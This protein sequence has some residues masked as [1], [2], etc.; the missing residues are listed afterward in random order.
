[1]PAVIKIGLDAEE[2]FRRT[3][4]SDA[5]SISIRYLFRV[6]LHLCMI[7]FF[8]KIPVNDL[9][10]N[11]SFSY[12]GAGEHKMRYLDKVGFSRQMYTCVSRVVPL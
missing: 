4:S 2:A 3:A 11:C 6:K 5:V 8:F 9:E 10:I 12:I 1:M 7:C